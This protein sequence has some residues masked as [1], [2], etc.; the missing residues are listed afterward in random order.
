MFLASF[1]TSQFKQY[2]HYSIVINLIGV[3]L[4]KN[5]E[6][7]EKFDQDAINIFLKITNIYCQKFCKNITWNSSS[8]NCGLESVS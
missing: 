6:S 7:E 1:Y 8:V 5:D 4:E 2:F 3:L